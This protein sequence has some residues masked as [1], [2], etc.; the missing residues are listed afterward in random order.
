M[1]PPRNTQFASMA[2]VLAVAASPGCNPEPP[3]LS[4]RAKAVQVLQADPPAGST[5][6]GGITA[7]DG[8]GCGPL[9]DDGT[10]DGAIAQIRREA[11]ARG[12]NYV[13]MIGIIPPRFKDGC[14]NHTFTIIGRVFRISAMA[15]KQ[16]NAA[17]CDP[18]CSPGYSCESGVCKGLPCNPPCESGYSCQSGACKASCNPACTGGMVCRQDRTCGPVVAPPVPGEQL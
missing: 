10:F 15:I 3:P 5:D 12:G 4:P 7:Y 13:E 14:Q 9:S 16:A 2:I 11:A 8:I 6:L 1:R 18:P 17:L